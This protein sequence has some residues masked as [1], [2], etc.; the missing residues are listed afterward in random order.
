MYYAVLSNVFQIFALSEISLMTQ[1]S[2]FIKNDLYICSRNNSNVSLRY[3]W[4]ILV[5]DCT[6]F[7]DFLFFLALYVVTNLVVPN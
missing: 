6:Q 5:N 3:I 2:I 1:F 4:S 7:L